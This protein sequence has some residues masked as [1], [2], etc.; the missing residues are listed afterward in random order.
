MGTFTD[1]DLAHLL[2]EAGDSFAVPEFGAAV[3]MDAY[4]EVAAV[5][6]LHRRRWVQLS[7][8]AAVAAVG[9]VLGVSLF[10]GNDVDR[11]GQLA[12]AEQV[13]PRPVPAP[14]S[15]AGAT[16]LSDLQLSFNPQSG[17]LDTRDFS[18]ESGRMPLAAGLA[19]DGN[20]VFG[21]MD[22]LTSVAAPGALAQAESSAGKAAA[23][24]PAAPA[25]AP[26]AGDGARIVKKGAIALIV[27]DDEVTPTLTEVQGFATAAGGDV[28]VANTQESGPTPS[29]SVTLRVPVGA[30]EQV[31]DQVRGM[32]ADVRSATTSG[33]DVTAQY[34]DVQ[35]QIRSLT[36]ARERFLAI[37]SEA[38]SIGDVLNVQQR[39]D[40]TTAK[41]DRLEGQRKVLADQ[42][43]KATL[44]VTVTEADDP[45]VTRAEPDT[46]LSKA[47]SD[48]GTGFRTGVEA[49]VRLSGRGVLLLLLAGLAYAVV[50]SA[51]K[52]S[53]RRLV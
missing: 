46:G 34:A 50:R 41:I 53:R 44:E 3:V 15:S 28:A 20:V 35:A 11:I 37:L 14:A 12:G 17:T 21:A 6:P 18:A 33:Q 27:E 42:S 47:F 40:D 39:V 13:A 49:L 25:Q 38:N 52:V 22:R 1:A 29:G 16:A 2:G 31:V 9:M 32:G 45:V 51:W 19:P 43:E 23:P 5:V 4:E 24:A 48:A 36:A 8:A 7:S 10:G 26:V 30:F